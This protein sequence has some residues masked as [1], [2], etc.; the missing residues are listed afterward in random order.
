MSF[1]YTSTQKLCHLICAHCSF[2]D[3]KLEAERLKNW[4]MQK[5][6]HGA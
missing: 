1:Q 6:L 2:K 4:F 5:E 3:I